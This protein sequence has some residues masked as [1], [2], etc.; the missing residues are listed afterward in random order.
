MEP[1][2]PELDLVS[3]I[4]EC[5]FEPSFVSKNVST[6]ML[7]DFDVYGYGQKNLIM[8]SRHFMT[9]HN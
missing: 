8:Q 1:E 5:S 4:S 6:T 3:L 7:F 2:D 9:L